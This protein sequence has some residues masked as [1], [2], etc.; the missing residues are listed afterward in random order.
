MLGL[1]RLLLL[2]QMLSSQNLSLLIQ[3]LDLLIHLIN[4]EILLFLLF[5]ELGYVLLSSIGRS[6]G[7][8][9]CLLHLL[10]VV[11]DLL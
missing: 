9:D 8:T 1:S 3:S 11:L 2:S 4:Q 7:H 6:L 10:V 5:L